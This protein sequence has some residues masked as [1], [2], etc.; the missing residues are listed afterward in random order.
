[1]D[2]ETGQEEYVYLDRNDCEKLNY[3]QI[4]NELIKKAINEK[5]HAIDRNYKGYP[6]IYLRGLYAVNLNG[7]KSLVGS[8]FIMFIDKNKTE[9]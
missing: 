4:K 1:M 9:A 3:E 5:A 7:D 2:N 8:R 6:N